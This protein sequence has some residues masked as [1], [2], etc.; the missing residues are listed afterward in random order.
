[1]EPRHRLSDH[2]YRLTADLLRYQ[3]AL[4]AGQMGVWDWDVGE[5]E[6]VWSDTL[7]ELHGLAPGAF[8]GTRDAFLALVQADDRDRVSA[9][10]RAALA[11]E[12]SYDLEFRIVQPSGEVRWIRGVGEV[13]R[14]PDGR[15]V[16]M[17]GVETDITRRREAEQAHFESEHR[18]RLLVEQLPSVT[19]TTTAT[20]ESR[21]LFI[22]PQ[23]E[24]LV[25]YRPEEFLKDAHLWER[26]L[27]PEKR[28]VVGDRLAACL[29]DGGRFALEYPVTARDGRTVW[30]RD[31]ARMVCDADGAP[32]F[33]QGILVDVTDR[34]LAE[35]A[36]HDRAARE[37]SL[38]ALGRQAV[39]DSDPS[40]L[41]AVA[42][43][44]AVDF[45]PLDLCDVIEVLPGGETGR[46]RESFGRPPDR[47]GGPL[48]V[49]AGTEAAFALRSSDTVLI[50][51]TAHER[52]FSVPQPLLDAGMRSG[53][54]ARIGGRGRAFGVLA[55]HS[56]R[57]DAFDV[58]DAA[59]VQ[60][61]A[62]VLGSAIGRR[63]A[64]EQLLQA[65]KMEAVGRLAG[66]I[67]HDFNNVLTAVLGYAELLRP[68]FDGDERR[69]GWVREIVE[70]GRRA[71]ALVDQL[72]SFS[73]GQISEPVPLDVGEVVRGM[74]ALIERVIGEQVVLH[75]EL[76]PA[77]GSTMNDPHRIEQVVLNLA[78]NARDAMPNGG[79]L[80]ISTD[81]VELDR[82]TAERAGVASGPY[83]RLAVSDNG[84]GMDAATVAQAVEPFFTTK[85]RGK[86]TGLGLSTVYGIVSGSRGHL[87]IRTEAGH[88][89]TMSVYLPR[90]D[91]AA[92][93]ED[94]PPE[95][96]MP[97]RGS[98]TVLLVED[99]QAVRAL[100][101]AVLRE[102]GYEVLE[103]VD[104]QDALGLEGATDVDLL[105]TDIVMPRVDGVQLTRR[106]RAERPGLPVL[107]MSGH[108][109]HAE[110]PD[111][112]ARTAFLPKPFGLVEL[113][114]CVRGVLDGDR[115]GA[116]R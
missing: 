72:L 57:P 46:L 91:A 40:A 5:D 56:L 13:L 8:E 30:V 36:L 82:V 95:S 10:L 19:Y 48:Q 43:A 93:R 74:R 99:Q 33:L 110:P 34:K 84:I 90:V 112:D 37:S 98:E 66:G 86:G 102:H 55:A 42:V 85:E 63:Q 68:A 18:Y 29:T 64:E 26:C 25:G 17:L 92:V 103:A 88:G 1:M 21:T 81:N 44:V 49:G 16:R 24:G 59:F 32:L 109:D 62:N 67:A 101:G 51:D 78:V 75:T 97:R 60:S 28:G 76:D 58:D 2:D 45:L 31:E 20:P 50:A 71:S 70:A 22:S 111:T 108:S 100:V 104:G 115:E 73:R 27:P 105:V 114:R 47:R 12:R 38:T 106:L 52:R 3:L 113:L 39:E 96:E 116:Q 15:P 9:A 41:F 83:V 107:Y 69:Q 14:S 61:V 53:V 11:G 80:T 54:V 79:T 23:I 65:Q 7:A 89:A 87:E 77:L 94:R 4:E 6:V 35:R